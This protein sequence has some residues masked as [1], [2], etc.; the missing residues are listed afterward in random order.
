MLVPRAP[1]RHRVARWVIQVLLIAGALVAIGSPALAAGHVGRDPEQPRP[2]RPPVGRDRIPAAPGLEER[3]RHHLFGRRPVT[4]QPEGVV[5]D[6]FGARVEDCTERVRV[7]GPGTPPQLRRWIV[8]TC[9]LARPA[10][11]VPMTCVTSSSDV[12]ERPIER[13]LGRE[14]A[15]RHL[16]QLGV[17]GPGSSRTRTRPGTAALPGRTS[18]TGIPLRTA[19]TSAS[20]EPPARLPG[21]LTPC[22]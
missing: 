17:G 11:R 2:E 7:P 9:Q 6:R 5:V 19:A 22:A 8:H 13:E 12:L 20:I 16:M 18:A 14:V 15:A 10:P 4:G 21:Q 1:A 3:H